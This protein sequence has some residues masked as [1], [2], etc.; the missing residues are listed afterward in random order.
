MC[1]IF[2]YFFRG[3]HTA[4]V[5]SLL[6]WCSGEDGRWMLDHILYFPG[7]F[8]LKVRK[9]MKPHETRRFYRS[10]SIYSFEE[11]MKIKLLTLYPIWP[12]PNSPLPSLS[13]SPSLPLCLSLPLLSLPLSL[14]V[15]Y[16]VCCNTAFPQHLPSTSHGRHWYLFLSNAASPV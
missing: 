11:P 5:F 16:M 4:D 14:L 3:S 1:F 9:V 15:K 2:I 13:F 6:W 7:A 10:N 8:D 12:R